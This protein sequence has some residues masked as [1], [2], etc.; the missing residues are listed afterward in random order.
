MVH[1]QQHSRQAQLLWCY[2][3]VRLPYPVGYANSLALSDTLSLPNY[4]GTP[5]YGQ[6]NIYKLLGQCGSLDIEDVHASTLHLVNGLSLTR[7]GKGEIFVMGGSHGGF[8]AAHLISRYPDI[9]SAAVLRNPVISCGDIAGTDIPDWYFAEFG[10]QNDFPV[11]SS[12]TFDLSSISKSSVTPN[13]DATPDLT[14]IIYDKLYEA[15]PSTAL[16]KYL[17]DRSQRPEPFARLPPV[18]L[19]IGAADQ[20]VA[21]TQGSAFYHLLKGAGEEVEMLIFEGEG[22]PLEGVEAA[23]VGWE[24]SR[25]WLK[26]FGREQMSWVGKEKVLGTFV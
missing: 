19:L 8:I 14:P 12:P 16:L 11:H 17:K 23:K 18:L 22:H 24:A 13:F 15:S 7:H 25:D 9:Y 3:D 5:G 10:F 4:T 21:P 26:K 20:R 1:Q 2:K 6:D